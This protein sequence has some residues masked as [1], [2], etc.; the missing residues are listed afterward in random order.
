[1][2]AEAARQCKAVDAGLRLERGGADMVVGDGLKQQLACGVERVLV[3][4][5]RCFWRRAGAA[6]KRVGEGGNDAV[7]PSAEPDRSRS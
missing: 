2:C 3:A 5:T 7:E 6:R 4:E 1:M